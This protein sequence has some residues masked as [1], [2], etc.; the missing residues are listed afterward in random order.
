MALQDLTPQL[1]TRLSR[2]ERAVGWFVL[3]AVALLT[4]GLGYYLYNTA[5][6]KGW[7]KT[8]A[9]YFTFT[10]RATGLKVGD[11]VQLMG[12]GVGQITRI[13]AQPPYD[14]YNVYLEFE[15]KAPYF[16]YLWTEGSRAKVATAD[17]LGK[18]VLEVT[19]GTNGYPAYTFHPLRTNVPISEVQNSLDP[20]AWLL[21]QEIYDSSGTNVMAKAETPLI[22]CLPALKTAGAQSLWIMRTNKVRTMTGIWNRQEAR[23][24]AYTEETKPFWLL[25][26]E[27]AAVTERLEQLVSDIE[28]ALPGI[29]ALTNQ[30]SAVLSNSG[31]LTSNL[32]VV[33]QAA[34][35][36]VSNIAIATAHLD[37]P[38]TLGEW[39]LPTNIIQELSSTLRSANTT[40]TSVDTNITSLASRLDLSLTSLANITSNL[41]NQVQMN[42]NLVSG[43]SQTIV[44][45]DNLVQ[46]LKHHWLLRSAFKTPKT[47]QAAPK[48]TKPLKSPKNRN[49]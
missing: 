9:P 8:K 44:D 39:L 32:N 3:I 29:L 5:E 40:L 23:Y 31:M 16:G 2:M 24:D 41:D 17:L 38:G 4:V 26:D 42:T 27:S 45:A 22:N 28:D 37:G 49:Q 36:A 13:D 15:I 20:N 19:K 25:S 48:I 12:F 47:N 14:P 34:L 7:F 35:P 30:L 18:R 33:A 10:E 46:G 43:I 6:R 1:R 21:A 11:P